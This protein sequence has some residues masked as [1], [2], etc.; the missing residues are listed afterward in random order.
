M[1][2]FPC[3]AVFTVSG[4]WTR[5]SRRDP[6]TLRRRAKLLVA[7]EE[8]RA[9]RLAELRGDAVQASWGQQIRSYVFHPYKVGPHS[10]SVCPSGPGVVSGGR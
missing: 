6:A 7:L 1:K 2:L 3:E 4:G 9:A 5:P 8:Q 10:R